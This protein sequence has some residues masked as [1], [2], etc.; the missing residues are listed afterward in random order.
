MDFVAQPQQAD[1]GRRHGTGGVHRGHRGGRRAALHGE[2]E[3]QLADDR[4]RDQQI[5]QRIGAEIAER[6]LAGERAGRDG[7]RRERDA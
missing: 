5:E 2:A 3:Q 7:R 6:L 1:D 4:V